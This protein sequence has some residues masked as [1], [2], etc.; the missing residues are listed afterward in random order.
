MSIPFLKQLPSTENEKQHF[1]NLAIADILDGT[2]IL[3]AFAQF[4]H[5]EDTLERIKSDPQVKALLENELEKY[6][7]GEKAT[8]MGYEISLGQRR[9]FDYSET[10]DYY[11]EEIKGKMK[12]FADQV[13][14]REKFLQSLKQK[15]VDAENGGFEI[16]PPKC[17][18]TTYPILKEV[19]QSIVMPESDGLAF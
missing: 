18:Y 12:G 1:V 17:S 13:K 15:I 3:Q 10:G 2:D 14:D 9:T 8:A 7:K 6:G 19:K 16:T 4:K 11:L 5:I